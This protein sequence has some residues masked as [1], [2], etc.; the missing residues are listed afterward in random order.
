[1]TVCTLCTR[2]VVMRIPRLNSE[3]NDVSVASHVYKYRA[4]TASSIMKD[5]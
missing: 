3:Q 1:M 4:I 2:S 5:Y